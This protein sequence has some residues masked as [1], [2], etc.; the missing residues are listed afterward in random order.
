[1][2]VKIPIAIH[3]APTMD[4]GWKEKSHADWAH[5][6]HNAVNAQIINRGVIS[7]KSCWKVTVAEFSGSSFLQEPRLVE[8]KVENGYCVKGERFLAHSKAKRK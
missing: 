3:V 5:K 1:M 2:H 4:K 7:A 8:S 6:F